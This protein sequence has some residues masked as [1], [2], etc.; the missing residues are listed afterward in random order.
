MSFENL[1]DQILANIKSV[2]K[3]NSDFEKQNNVNKL[4]FEKQINFSEHSTKKIDLLE[5]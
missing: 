1:M 2:E 4:R 3:L 5:S